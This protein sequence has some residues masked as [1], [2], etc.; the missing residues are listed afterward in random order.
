MLHFGGTISLNG[1]V[2]FVAYNFE[3]VLLGRF[4]GAEDLGLYGRAYQ[5]ITIPTHNL[6]AAVGG[7]AVSALSRLHSDPPRLKT[8]FLKA[9]AFVNSLTL[10]TTIFCVLF[11]DEII[12]VALGP[13]WTGAAPVFRMLAPT[14]LVFGLINPLAWLLTSIGL[15]KRSLTIALVIAPVVMTAYVLGLPYGPAGVAFAY[16]AAMVLWVIPHVL[17]CL[18]G[19]TISARDLFGQRG[20]RFFSCRRGC[21]C[22]WSSILYWR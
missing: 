3:K 19:T 20:G 12:A 15:Q 14:V 22:F 18:N 11:A 7:V 1:L 21:L 17:W 10:P 6:N 2:V 5:L 16:S 4:W 9:Y 13:N 8:Y